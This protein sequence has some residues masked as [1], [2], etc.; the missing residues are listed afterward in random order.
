MVR[1]GERRVLVVG[2]PRAGKTAPLPYPAGCRLLRM[3]G[4]QPE[5]ALAFAELRQ[6]SR[7]Y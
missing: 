7:R 2:D 1:D 6:F 3:A 4:A 5:M